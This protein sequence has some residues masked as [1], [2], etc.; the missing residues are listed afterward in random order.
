M[1]KIALILGFQGGLNIPLSPPQPLQHICCEGLFMPKP[2][3]NAHNT[4]L[5]LNRV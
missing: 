2:Q 1:I 5:H 3:D 4:G